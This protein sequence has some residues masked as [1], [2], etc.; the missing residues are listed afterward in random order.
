MPTFDLIVKPDEIDSNGNY[1]LD[2]EAYCQI[3]GAGI[4]HTVE[5]SVTKRRGFPCVLLEPCPK[6]MSDKYEE[7]VSD[8]HDKS[9]KEGYVAGEEAGEEVGYAKGYA[10]AEKIHEQTQL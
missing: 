1:S 10:D 6:C 2:F 4:C 9:Y 5:V 3:C 7:G 8:T